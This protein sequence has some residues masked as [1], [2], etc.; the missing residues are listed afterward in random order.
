MRITESLAKEVG[1][2]PACTAMKVS[3]A[4]LYRHR[5]RPDA[6]AA[7]TPRPAP[8]LAL[9]D[10]ERQ[11]VL[12]TLH[13]PRFVDA[14]PYQVWA[15]LLDDG[16]N[17]C[18]VRTM[19]RLLQDADEVRE[20]RNLLRR[21]AYRKPELLATAPNQV[22]SWDITKLK[23]PHKWNFFYLYVI[24]DIYS[25]Y[26]VGWMLAHR[27]C[28]TLAQRLVAETLDK[29]GIP[30]GQ[31]TLHADRGPSATAT[32]LAQFL[33]TM[34]VSIS[35]SRPHTSNDNPYSEA[36][37]KTLKYNP[38][39][40]QRFGSFEDARAFC[41]SF[42]NWYNTQHRHSSLA[43][44]TPEQVHYGLAKQILEQRT[45]V[46][47]AA[48]KANPRRFK[49]R[50]PKPGNLPQAVWI[51]PPA[52]DPTPSTSGS[53]TGSTD[54]ADTHPPNS[55][56]SRPSGSRCGQPTPPDD[57]RQPTTTQGGKADEARENR[58]MTTA[59][60]DPLAPMVPAEPAGPQ[61][62]DGPRELEHRAT[63]PAGRAMKANDQPRMLH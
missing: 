16:V 2:M 43:L 1:I 24:L 12:D 31:L 25:R 28:Q 35:H 14:T 4:T 33:A 39:F 32:S 5:G 41:A 3:R 53:A 23:G 63:T 46:L 52:P 50:M 54:T 60:P 49:G 17:L 13:S 44:L 27:E 37:F 7:P 10:E 61:V 19:Y 8:P 36:Q 18:S 30:P 42:F 48:F 62:P 57:L 15:E 47:Q 34:A 59:L 45:R 26:T 55:M 29:H 58:V 21:P 38:H 20:R 11:E 56:S 22:W 51:N 40:P 6:P 9:S